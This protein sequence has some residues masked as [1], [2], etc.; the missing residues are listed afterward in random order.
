MDGCL[1]V[2]P[3]KRRIR[4]LTREI[5]RLS[6]G[7]VAPALPL[8]TMESLCRALY[9]AVPGARTVIGGP[10]RTLLFHRAVRSVAGGLRYFSLRGE[11]P[12]LPRGVFFF[13][14]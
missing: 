5:M 2:V 14:L 12:Q 13:R 7:A 11:I 10:P 9:A 4:H 6:P 1:V 8:H 3:T